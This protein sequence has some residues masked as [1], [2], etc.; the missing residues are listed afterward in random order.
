MAEVERI[1]FR[2]RVAGEPVG[3]IY[4]TAEEPD[5]DFDGVDTADAAAD[6]EILQTEMSAARAV[7]N[8]RSLDEDHRGTRRDGQLITFNLRAVIVHMV[9]EYAR[10]NGHADLLREAIDGAVGS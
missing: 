10:H 5:W 8:S 1:W 7:Q 3:N 9:E 4:C 2:V 6:L